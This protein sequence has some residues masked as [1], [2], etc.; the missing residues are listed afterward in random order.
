M[1]T[2]SVKPDPGYLAMPD[3]VNVNLLPVGYPAYLGYVDGEFQTANALR[4]MFPDAALVLLTVNGSTNAAHGARVAAGDDIEPGDLT[5]ADAADW[6]AEQIRFGHLSGPLVMYAS[7]IGKPGYGMRDVAAE[8]DR[9]GIRQPQVRLLSAHYGRGPH[10]CGPH[11]CGA[12]G[13]DMDGTQWT[14]AYQVPGGVVDMSLLRP[15]FF[16]TAQP[17]S[18]ET[19]RLVRELGI[20]RQGD[21]GE[22]VRTVQALCQARLKTTGPRIDGAFG[23]F[24]ANAVMNVQ[25]QASIEQDGVVGPKTWPVLLGVA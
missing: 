1:T 23:Q 18:T 16:S 15:G 17:G 11:S 12:I 22:A 21:T 10:I 5:A 13:I 3:A 24:T 8:L 25:H 4:A 9:R 14:D 2:M 7:V 20:V 6:A 19:E